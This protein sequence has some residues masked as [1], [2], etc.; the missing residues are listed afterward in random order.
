MSNKV[1]DDKYEIVHVIKKGGFGIVYYGIDRTLNKP[2][3]IKEIVPNRLENAKYIHMFHKEALNIAK[4]IWKQSI[5][6]RVDSSYTL[7][8]YRALHR[9]Y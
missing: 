7:F 3:A 1:L 2:I 6:L 5:F 8:V 9:E 4:L